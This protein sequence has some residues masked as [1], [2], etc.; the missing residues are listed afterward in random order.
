MSSQ[1]LLRESYLLSSAVQDPYTLH[2]LDTLQL[3]LLTAYTTSVSY[4][5]RR[6]FYTHHGRRAHETS[7]DTAL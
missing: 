7:P 1:R 2:E 3:L 6:A 5:G 4:L